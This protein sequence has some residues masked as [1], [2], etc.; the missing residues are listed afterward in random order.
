MA[1]TNVEKNQIAQEVTEWCESVIQPD[2][3]TVKTENYEGKIVRTSFELYRLRKKLMKV[4][5]YAV[6]TEFTSLRVQAK[7]VAEITGVSF[8][9]GRFNNYYVPLGHIVNTDEEQLSIDVFKRIMGCVFR[10][11]DVRVIGHNLKAEMHILANYGIY[12]ATTDLF[13]TLVAVWNLDENNEC[14]LKEVTERYYGYHQRHFSDLLTTITAETKKEFGIPVAKAGNASL[15][16]IEI[17]APYAMDDTYWTWN[18]YLDIYD[19][20]EE[21]GALPYFKK[22]QM[23]YLR[24][25]F[26]MERRGVAV[27]LKR[28]RQMEKWAIA[29]MEKLTYQ[30]YEMVGMEF[31]I[32]SGEQLAMLLFGWKK[33]KPIYKVKRTPILDDQGNEQVYK[34]GPRKGEVKYKETKLK[35]QIIGYEDSYNKDLVALSY[36]FPVQG[37]T[38]TGIP[39]S[40]GDS[41]DALL[42]IEYKRD[43]RKMEGQKLVRIIQDFNRLKKLQSAFIE[44]ILNNLYP[45]GKIHC[46]YNQ[47]GTTSGRLS[48]QN[49]NLQQLPRPIEPVYEPV[50]EKYDTE[51]EYKRAVKIYKELKREYD[52]WIRYEIRSLFV[53]DDTTNELVLAEDFSNLEMRILTHFSQ[54]ELLISMFERDADAH[55]DTAVNMYK[56]NCDPDE[57]KKL[58]PK[59]RQAAKTLNFLLVYGGSPIALASQLGIPKKEAQVMYDLYFDTY[60]G[61]SN[62]MAGQKKYGHRHTVVYTVL[63]RKRHLDGINAGDFKTVGY[64]ERLSVNAPVQGSAADIAISAQI[65]IEEDEILMDNGYVQLMQIHDEIVGTCPK[66]NVEVCAKRVQY[67][68]ENCLPKP[69]KNVKLKVDYDWGATYAEAK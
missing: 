4:E 17:M 31:N 67:L 24:V 38:D 32:G 58:Y 20:L 28:L 49:I 27:D 56:L 7:G 2:G 66:E 63:G 50:R 15:I 65:L 1:K 35:D 30:I 9:W 37:T 61:V 40:D 42:K 64:Y 51:L 41:L 25:L 44:G 29:D 11:K 6:D 8:S 26:N 12:F 59:E 52:F 53:P 48:C 46:S 55:G 60:Q 19:A 43:K 62:Y 39:Q 5:E 57:A 68:M 3:S 22:R 45:D 54:D 13:D 21:E 23:P 36:N 10:R 14:G 34:S 18:I 16:K 69:L 47:T 33:Q